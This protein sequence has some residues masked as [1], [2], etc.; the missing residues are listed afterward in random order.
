MVAGVYP[1]APRTE[2]PR[3]PLPSIHSCQA[4][5][6]RYH[7]VFGCQKRDDGKVGC[8]WS[9]CHLYYSDSR[10]SREATEVLGFVTDHDHFDLACPCRGDGLTHHRTGIRIHDNLGHD[11]PPM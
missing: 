9:R 3:G 5:Y 6:R 8:V 7:H 11:R 10:P 2:G 1:M 4:R